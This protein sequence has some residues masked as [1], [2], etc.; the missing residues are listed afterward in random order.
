MWNL[1]DEPQA[2]AYS[3]AAYKQTLTTEIRDHFKRRPLFAALRAKSMKLKEH[4]RRIISAALEIPFGNRTKSIEWR[5]GSGRER[6][7]IICCASKVILEKIHTHTYTTNRSDQIALKPQL[8][9]KT[10]KQ[11]RDTKKEQAMRKSPQVNPTK[12]QW[13][14]NWKILCMCV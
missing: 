3:R 7:N 6:P 2:L 13:K 9:N 4:W 14:I 11:N 12:C 10:W 1:F 5:R 8:I